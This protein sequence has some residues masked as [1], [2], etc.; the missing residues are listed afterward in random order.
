MAVPASIILSLLSLANTHSHE[1]IHMNIHS[2]SQEHSALCSPS[3]PRLD[4][5]RHKEREQARESAS[6]RSLVFV[7]GSHGGGMVN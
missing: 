1:H 6:R 4:Y 3:V 5:H 2:I 7:S